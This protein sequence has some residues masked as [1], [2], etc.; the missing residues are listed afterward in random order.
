MYFTVAQRGARAAK[1]R[2]IDPMDLKEFSSV[3][4][5][6]WGPSYDKCLFQK[7]FRG[8]HRAI[9]NELKIPK[10]FH[11]LDVGCGTA[12]ASEACFAAGAA[13]YVGAD[14]AKTMLDVANTTRMEKSDGR[15]KL[16]RSDS[17]TLP[18]KDETFD[19]VTCS[20]SFHHYP[21]PEIALAEMVRSLKGGGK[22]AILEMRLPTNFL[23]KLH[24]WSVLKFG[25]GD[26]NVYT[27]PEKTTLLK[28][29]GLTNIRHRR[30]G[31]IGE[32]SIGE[33]PPD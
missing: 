25:Q 30:Y 33:K 31:I 12:A 2:G 8:G 20:M 9:L 21:H 15:I 23:H 28:C 11:I 6:Q 13:S 16:V 17:E 1:E 10:G 32:I 26:V 22:L 7:W 24:R 5:E 4:F 14:M 29:A 19:A 27:N 18:F 3:H